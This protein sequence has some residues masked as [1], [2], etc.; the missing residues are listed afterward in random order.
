[1]QCGLVQFEF[2]SYFQ[3]SPVH[4]ENYLLLLAITYCLEPRF[5]RHLWKQQY[6]MLYC[7]I[8]NNKHDYLVRFLSIK[9][10]GVIVI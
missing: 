1:M 6:G 2:Y 4:S 9:T 8:E 10:L 7:D 3:S 5:V